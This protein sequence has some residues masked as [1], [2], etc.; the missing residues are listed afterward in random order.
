MIDGKQV[1]LDS[2]TAGDEPFM[3]ASNLPG[4]PVV[5]VSGFSSRDHVVAAVQ[6]GAAGFLT[7][8]VDLVSLVS[9]L[10]EL[11]SKQQLGHKSFWVSLLDEDLVE[12]RA[13]GH[14]ISLACAL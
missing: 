2:H 9:R 1:L 12:M 6:A 14:A 5:I 3:L 4:V 8:P 13:D 10:D 11:V 7:R